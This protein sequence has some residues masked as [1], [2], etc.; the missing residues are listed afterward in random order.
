MERP[1][2]WTR[3]GQEGTRGH[4]LKPHQLMAVAAPHL[5]LKLLAGRHAAPDSTGNFQDFDSLFKQL[6]TPPVFEL[7]KPLPKARFMPKRCVGSCPAAH[8]R[9][10]LD[11]L[12]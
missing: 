12:N 3:D 9:A 5:S 6:G 10:L 1:D 8:N 7:G 2:G 4:G 11:D